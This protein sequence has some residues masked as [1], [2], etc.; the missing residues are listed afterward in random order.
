MAAMKLHNR[1]ATEWRKMEYSRSSFAC[2]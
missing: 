2:M 1:M